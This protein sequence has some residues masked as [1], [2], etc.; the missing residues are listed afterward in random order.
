MCNLLDLA[1]GHNETRA[2]KCFGL[3]RLSRH[4]FPVGPGVILPDLGRQSY[5]FC[6]L[7]LLWYLVFSGVFTAV[8]S[9]IYLVK[10]ATKSWSILADCGDLMHLPLD[11]QYEILSRKD[12]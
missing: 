4:H 8:V 6:V 3:L 7:D 1:S 12:F 9:L 2:W 5:W 11:S 10:Q